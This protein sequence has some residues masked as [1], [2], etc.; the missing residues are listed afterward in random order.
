MCQVTIQLPDPLVHRA[1][2]CASKEGVT[3]DHYLTRVLQA[4]LTQEDAKSMLEA[5]LAGKSPCGI[6]PRHEEFM[7]RTTDGD[8]PTSE[9]IRAALSE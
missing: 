9:H 3:L 2:E 7:R 6:R 8:E 1:T 4:I 5:R